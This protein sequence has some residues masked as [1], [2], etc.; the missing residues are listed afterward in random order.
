MKASPHF[1]QIFGALFL[2]STLAGCNEG[3]SQSD[4]DTLP[5]KKLFIAELCA[6]C[7]GFERQGS[8]MGPPL[9]NLDENWERHNLAEFIRTPSKFTGRD[10]RIKKLSKQFRTQMAPNKR[11]SEDERLILA[12]WLLG[13]APGK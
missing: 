5:G 6:S 3:S 2:L 1:N 12:D 9:R 7:H 13:T 11:L 8:W 10:E 4:A